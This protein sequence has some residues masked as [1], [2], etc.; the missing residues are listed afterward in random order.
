MNITLSQELESVVQG[1]IAR[2]EYSGIDDLIGEAVQRLIDEDRE[3]HLCLDVIRE[4]IGAAE[5]QIERGDFI[6][7]D[8]DNIRDLVKDVRD[9]GMKRL[10]SE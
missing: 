4:R 10:S 8:A 2:G 6:D 5:A 3:E 9:R 7:Y 1:K